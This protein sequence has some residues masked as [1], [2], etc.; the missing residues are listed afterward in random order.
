MDWTGSSPQVP[1]GINTH[2][3]FTRSC[4]YAAIRS[5]CAADVPNCHGSTR[6]IAVDAPLGA[7]LNARFPA[8]CGARG[9]TGFRIID[10]LFG[11]LAQAMPDK[12]PA[13][14]FG[15]NSLV[16]LGFEHERK[17]QVFVET[18]LGNSG[19]A[20]GH[21]GQDAVPHLGANLAMCR[22]RCSKHRTRRS[23]AAMASSRT[24]A[25]PVVIAVAWRSNACTR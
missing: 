23:S 12:V 7:I 10:C 20:R 8:P 3:P 17:Q 22:W 13:D 9:I 24:A 2:L 25:A 16:G 21:D 6:A 19:G 18:V 14:N 4:C 11:A 1:G 15:G 5:V